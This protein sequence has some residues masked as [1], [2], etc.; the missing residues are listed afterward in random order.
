MLNQ[1]SNYLNLALGIDLKAERY[2]NSSLPAFLNW[3]YEFYSFS[4]E[5]H[6]CLLAIQRPDV[7]LTPMVIAKNIDFLEHQTGLTV[8]FAGRSLPA[9]ERQRLMRVKVPFIVPGRQLYLPF[10]SI[11][12]SEYGTKKQQVFTAIGTTAQ[13]LLLK[14]LNGF[15]ESFSISEAMATAGYTKPSV[16]RAFDELEFF[17]TGRRHG[18]ERHLHFLGTRAEQWKEILAKL[19]NPCRRIVGL[20]DLPP[21]LA[22]VPSGTEA[23]AMRSTLN[24]PEWREL[25]A[26]HTDYSRL[27]PKEIPVAEAPLRLELWN[28]HPLVMPDGG[29][30]PF[31]LWLVLQN[32]HDE[33]VQMCLEEMMKDVL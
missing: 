9:Y 18:K 21:G 8:I 3:N 14:W 33:R 23:L 25:A 26:F 11:A 1:I 29:V 2:D 17:G 28:Y 27:K 10:A 20:E 15:A 22:A 19:S 7:Q 32:E 31:S 30:D 4:L 5:T 24:P 16:I 13:I 12:L 6:S